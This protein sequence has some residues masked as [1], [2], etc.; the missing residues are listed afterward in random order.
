MNQQQTARQDLEKRNNEAERFA[1]AN[2]PKMHHGWAFSALLDSLFHAWSKYNQLAEEAGYENEFLNKKTEESLIEYEETKRAIL[3]LQ[4][5]KTALS[6]QYNPTGNLSGKEWTVKTA[7]Y[8]RRYGRN[9]IASDN[10]GKV[11]TRIA[12]EIS[13]GTRQPV[14]V[15]SD[16]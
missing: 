1:C 16:F 14:K 11:K 4:Q 15:N 13:D 2:V 5:K 8:S 10:G 7:R 9:K 3:D 6:N 12:Q